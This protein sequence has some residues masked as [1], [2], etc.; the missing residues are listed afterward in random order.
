[1]K[2]H[3]GILGVAHSWDGAA[4]FSVVSSVIERDAGSPRARRSLPLEW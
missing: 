2:R 4:Q 1:M 3:T